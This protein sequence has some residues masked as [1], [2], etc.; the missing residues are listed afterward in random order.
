MFNMSCCIFITIN[1]IEVSWHAFCPSYR[2][3]DTNNLSTLCPI[4]RVATAN[5]QCC[6]ALLFLDSIS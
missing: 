3:I 2:I 5:S 6:T 4:S 1:Q